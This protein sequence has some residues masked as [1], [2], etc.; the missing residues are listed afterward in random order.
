MK[1]VTE[2]GVA[3]SERRAISAFRWARPGAHPGHF[4]ASAFPA[5]KYRYRTIFFG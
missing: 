2:G 5:A 3:V 1:M 4:L